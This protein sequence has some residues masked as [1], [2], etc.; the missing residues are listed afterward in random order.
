MLKKRFIKRFASLLM[1][2]CLVAIT[3]MQTSA[4]A[5]GGTVV[6][7]N[8]EDLMKAIQDQQ[9]G[10]TWTINQ[11]DYDLKP[12][13][14]INIGNQ[15]GWF[16][17]IV[18]EGI[19]IN[20]VGNPVITTST[21]IKNGNWAT[22]DFIAVKA[23]NVSINGVTIK[24]QVETN[25]AIEVIDAKNFTLKNSTI[26]ARE[27]SKEPG[28]SGS[29][30]FTST[31]NSLSYDVGNSILENVVTHGPIKTLG[32]R[33]GHVLLKN[34]TLDLTVNS[35]M[36]RYAT[37]PMFG[38]SSSDPNPTV[39]NAYTVDNF[40]VKVD[41]TA[42][43]LNNQ[44]LKLVP[45]GTNIYFEPGRYTQEL[46]V[47]K[48]LNLFGLKDANGN[49]P[50]LFG[51][52]VIGQQPIDGFVIDGFK[53]YGAGNDI[54]ADVNASTVYI[55]N[56]KNV[57]ISNNGFAATVDNIKKH[58]AITTGDDLFGI[59]TGTVENLI[60]KNNQFTGYYCAN[61]NNPGSK[62][63]SFKDNTV[64]NG[65]S[66][67]AFVGIDGVTVTGNT[68][69]HTNGVSIEPNWDANAT[70]CTNVVITNNKFLS[71]STKSPFAVRNGNSTGKPG[72]AVAL[73][74]SKNYW[75][76]KPDF[77]KLIIGNAKV[78]PYFVNESMTT[79]YA[80]IPTV[81]GVTNNTTYT[82]DVVI[83]FENGTASLDGNVF[84]SGS[85][86]TANGT[87]TLVVTNKSGKVATIVF[88]IKK[89]LSVVIDGKSVELTP[90]NVPTVALAK[91]K[92]SVKF[93]QATLMKF[94]FGIL[95]NDGINGPKTKA[96]IKAFQKSVGLK[97]DGIYGPATR[98]AL[99]KKVTGG[100]V[101]PAPSPSTINNSSDV[102]K[103]LNKLGYGPLAVDGKI[104]PKT[105][106][107]I[108][109][110]QKAYRLVVDG[111]VGPKTKAALLAA[112]N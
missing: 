18:K 32:V 101:T 39:Y 92:P 63:I 102:Q 52:N 47:S 91:T 98:N 29:I 28:F 30:F 60:I 9:P 111:I 13:S 64:T 23:D 58:S 73:D 24:P 82:T 81:T 100:T 38:V 74:L 45:A 54:N 55:Q 49:K 59:V 1:L 3:L 5:I 19:T 112:I 43:D 20:G 53:F 72:Y 12:N 51:I 85:K 78:Y 17:P 40:K 56:A 33:N 103:I 48:S 16:F 42:I 107:V 87:H 66:R 27:E 35:Y 41:S 22:Q 106:A 89:Q 79:L 77:S 99:I 65:N 69:D 61:Y 34:T 94:G 86:V 95:V 36:S 7:N 11:G 88:T 109:A 76:V 62:N 108:K 25:K 90:A 80:D 71:Q 96:V 14:S 2:A 8:S 68:F 70:P 110:F 84:V 57:T 15:T 50:E 46:S 93:I 97:V 10:Q 31:D 105:T 67:V 83:S 6:I 21:P 26:L 44:V 104:G 37:F 4:F 75:G